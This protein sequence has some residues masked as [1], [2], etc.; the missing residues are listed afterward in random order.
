MNWKLWLGIVIS[1]I[2]LLLALRKVDF[3]ELG[4]ALQSAEYIY[5]LPASFLSI[6]SLWIRAYRWHYL[7]EHIRPIKMSSLFSATM[8][9][10]MANNLFPARFGEFVRAWAIG[11]KEGIRKSAS[12]ATIVLERILDGIT[13]LL[14]LAIIVIFWRFPFPNWLKNA[15]Y[16]SLGI[17]FFALLFLIVLKGQTERSIKLAQSVSRPLPDKVKSRFLRIMESFIEGLGILHS[18]KNIMIASFLSLFVWISPALSIYVLLI[19]SNIHLPIFCAF[20]LMVILCLG[21][22]IPSAPG[23]IGTVQFLSVAGLG[24][25]GIPK[26][27]ALSYSFLFHAVQFIP[28][29]AIGL[30]YL[31]VEGFSFSQMRGSSKIVSYSNE[32]PSRKD[33]NHE[34]EIKGGN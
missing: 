26:S 9:G 8:I 22:M 1:A 7:L 18:M 24:L 5:L 32:G 27:D 13:V 10:F 2:F 14:F 11:E 20:L 21:V 19:S 28:V 31:F 12:F 3:H 25:F 6:L 29:T 16:G 30:L 17:Y 33:D 4:N 34:S 15:A 23:Y